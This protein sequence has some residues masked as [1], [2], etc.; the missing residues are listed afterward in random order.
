MLSDTASP[1]NIC[2]DQAVAHSCL[3]MPGTYI[4]K[5]TNTQTYQAGKVL[6]FDQLIQVLENLDIV[7][8][9]LHIGFST[10]TKNNPNWKIEKA[11]YAFF[12]TY[13]PL[14]FAQI[15]KNRMLKHQRAYPSVS[16]LLEYKNVIT[17]LSQC[18][19]FQNI[20]ML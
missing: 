2:S 9:S 5:S 14:Y 12:F 1:D 13:Q 3:S 20:K 17:L 10:W 19:S 6:S 4:Q 18:H 15:W 16:F 8:E 7:L 11:Q